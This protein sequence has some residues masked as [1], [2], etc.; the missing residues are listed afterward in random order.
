MSKIIYSNLKKT[1]STTFNLLKK[2]K[3][4]PNIKLVSN[5]KVSKTSPLIWYFMNII[6]YWNKYGIKRFKTDLVNLDN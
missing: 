2:I 5:F 1:F 6:Y 3:E 4:K